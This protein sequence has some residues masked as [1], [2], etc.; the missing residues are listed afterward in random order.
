MIFLPTKGKNRPAEMLEFAEGLKNLASEIRFKV[1][2]R[3][4][5]YILEG[6]NLIT[7]AKFDHAE[8]II[9]DCRKMGLLP[10][11]FIAEEEGRQFSGVEFPDDMNPILFIRR[12]L[13]A[14][15]QAEIYYTPDWWADEEYYIQM[16]VEKIDLKTLFQPVCERFKIPIATSKGWSSI[17]QRAIFGRRFKEAE[18]KGLKC[19]LLYCGDHDPDGLKIDECLKKNLEDIKG[20]K[21][22][23]GSDGYDPSDLIIERFGLNYDFIINQNL[24][25]IENLITGSKK[26]LASPKHRNHF[27]PYVQKYIKEIG[28]RKCEANALVVKP[29]EGRDLCRQAIEKYLGKDGPERFEE[30]TQEVF[31]ILDEFRDKSGFKK[32]IEKAIRIIEEGE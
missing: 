21:W 11:D 22:E 14:A 7:K 24:T 10:V 3:G 12:Y 26:N 15:L 4:W 9:N 17:L 25:W 16:L 13:S 32:S 20:I 1:S 6:W 27:F 5:C 28:I 31:E 30:K 29:E 19:V 8:K 18:E 2:S 23:D